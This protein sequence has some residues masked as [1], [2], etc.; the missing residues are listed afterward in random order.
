MIGMNKTLP[1]LMRDKLSFDSNHYHQHYDI[2][3]L[4]KIKSNIFYKVFKLKTD[5]STEYDKKTLKKPESLAI[6]RET[7]YEKITNHNNSSI[8]S[9]TKQKEK[10][11]ELNV[12]NFF[13]FFS[14]IFLSLNKKK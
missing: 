9:L 7:L 3:I 8:F 10:K 11:I 1:S 14:I 13:L 12:K 5:N 4:E 6:S 2:K